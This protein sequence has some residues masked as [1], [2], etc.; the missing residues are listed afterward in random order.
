MTDCKQ[1]SKRI[2]TIALFLAEAIYFTEGLRSEMGKSNNK[3]FEIY[4]E[5]CD[6]VQIQIKYAH[7]QK[8]LYLLNTLGNI[9]L[10]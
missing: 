8:F 6:Y 7:T 2:I 9:F 5:N 10:T 3:N 4:L 1:I